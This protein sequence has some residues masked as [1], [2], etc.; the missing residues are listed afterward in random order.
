MKT[1]KT[2]ESI[3]ND[4]ILDTGSAQEASSYTLFEKLKYLEDHNRLPKTTATFFHTIRKLGNLGAH[5]AKEIR[6]SDFEIDTVLSMLS[7]VM[8]W[9]KSK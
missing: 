4:L 3:V 7:Y 1:R 2:M 9:H 8:Q 5:K 6:L